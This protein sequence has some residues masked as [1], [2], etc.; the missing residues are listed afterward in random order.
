MKSPHSITE[1]FWLF[2]LPSMLG[3]LLNSLFIIVD[4]FFIGQNL[5]D[6][7][8]AA[9]NVAWPA[10]ALIQAVSMAIGTGG[11]VQISIDIGRKIRIRPSGPA[12]IPL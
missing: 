9:I 11:A 12:A 3:Q 6:A 2:A 8:L 5:G 4:G 10:V 7:G 1:K